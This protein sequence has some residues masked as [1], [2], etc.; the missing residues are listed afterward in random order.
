QQQIDTQYTRQDKPPDID[1]RDK[2]R[3]TQ[4][5]ICG[6]QQEGSSAISDL[7]E[8]GF[9]EDYPAVDYVIVFQAVKSTTVYL[10]QATKHM[11]VYPLNHAKLSLD[12][13]DEPD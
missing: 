3:Q 5:G 10:M 11:H 4:Y 8:F 9:K 12:E 6:G 13:R 1:I 7:A 2:P